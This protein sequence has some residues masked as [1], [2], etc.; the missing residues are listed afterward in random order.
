MG[1]SFASPFKTSPALYITHCFSVLYL[2]NAS[3][4]KFAEQKSRLCPKPRNLASVSHSD[5]SSTSLDL[6]LHPVSHA[7]HSPVVWTFQKSI[8]SLLQTEPHSN[9]S[10]LASA[11]SKRLI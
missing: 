4:S 3:S 5:R 10:S 9:Y 8:V 2:T 1:I 7:N 6:F 11:E